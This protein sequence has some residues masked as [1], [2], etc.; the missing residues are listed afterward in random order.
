MTIVH[1]PVGTDIFETR[2]S[3][4][5]NP[6][7]CVGVMGKGL[8]L[9]FKKTFP[10]N[11]LAYEKAC[12]RR[13]LKP[14]G[15]FVYENAVIGNEQAP[16][17]WIVNLATK[18]HWRDPSRIEWIRD[19]TEALRQWALDHG[20]D[21]IACP[22]IGA[23]LGGLDWPEVKRT[24]EAVFE[25]GGIDLELY[26]PATPAPTSSQAQSWRHRP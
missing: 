3:A 15:I 12:R 20:V 24:I 22:A 11:F 23:G 6:V 26:E 9:A 16:C 2:S 10:E 17:R 25:D 18:D 13:E 4:I 8:A 19:G 21:T 5:V 14:G 7:N 1:R